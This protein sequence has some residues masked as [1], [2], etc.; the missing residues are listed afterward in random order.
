LGFVESGTIINEGVLERQLGSGGFGSVWQVTDPTNGNSVAYKIYHA[1]ELDNQEK[2]NRFATG[3]EAMKLL[4][5]PRIVRVHRYSTCPVGF[6]MDFVDG[7]N[8]RDLQ[9]H[10]ALEAVDLVDLMIDIA[11]AVAHAHEN[12]VIHRDIKPENIV[13]TLTPDGR[14]IP[15]LTDFDLAWFATRTQNATKS[16]LGVIFYAAPEQYSAFDPK[17]SG[18]K[19]PA[20]DVFSFGQL[21][22][23]C[24]VGRD[25]DPVRLSHN[26]S[27]LQSKVTGLSSGSVV[28]QLGALYKDSTAWNP[29]DRTQDFG[30]ILRRLWAIKEELT[31]TRAD[32]PVTQAEFVVELIYRMTNDPKV[33]RETMFTSLSGAWQVHLEWRTKVFRKREQP[34]LLVQFTPNGRIGFE[35]LSNEKMRTVLNERVDAALVTH[36]PNAVRH[37]GKQ[38]TFEVFVEFC[39]VQ[40]DRNGVEPV[41]L[42]IRSTL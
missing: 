14:Q 34:S 15:F 10:L 25:P 20:L 33:P 27:E 22:Y 30:E 41:R 12:S 37:K 23:F 21:L 2:I 40:L 32:A 18:A 13:C 1:Q 38:G 42:A 16:G 24:F 29:A 11:E 7:Q 4:R 26:L 28:R 17:V 31:H 8:L 36:R 35:N 6:V 19:T 5:H 39:P 3:Y 9:P